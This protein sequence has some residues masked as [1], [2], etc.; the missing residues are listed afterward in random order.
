MSGRYLAHGAPRSLL[1]RSPGLP[2][3]HACQRVTVA[4]QV[5]LHGLSNRSNR[6]FPRDITVEACQ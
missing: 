4:V 6:G 1:E 5:A 3:G 2:D